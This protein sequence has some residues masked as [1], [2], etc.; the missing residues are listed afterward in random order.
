MYKIHLIRLL[1]SFFNNSTK[2]PTCKTRKT[3][4]EL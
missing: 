1:H 4:H 2:R 3:T